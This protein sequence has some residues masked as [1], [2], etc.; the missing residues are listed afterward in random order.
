MSINSEILNDIY[1]A[2]KHINLTLQIMGSL[3]FFM[4]LFKNMGH[5]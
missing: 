1:I 3:L 5:K 2:L 4:L